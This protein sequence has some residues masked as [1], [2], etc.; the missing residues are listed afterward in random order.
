[1][2]TIFPTGR[3]RL[4]GFGLVVVTFLAGGLA[5]AAVDRVLTAEVTRR[6]AP[7]AEA[8]RTHVIDQVDMTADQRA[9]IDAILERR[10]ER[11]KAAWS[12][13]SPRLE[14]ITDSARHEIMQ[15]LTPAQ[16]AE[17]ERRLDAR[18][19]EREEERAREE[20]SSPDG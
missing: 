9:R 7:D 20:G 4:I 13:I 6:D 5:G 8:R 3:M 2:S 17:Y 19:K 12:E 11:M 14:A 15:V 18:I 10:S 1:V 16:Q